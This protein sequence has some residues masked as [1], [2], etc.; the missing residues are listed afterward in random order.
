MSAN[1][2]TNSDHPVNDSGGNSTA[3]S[4]PLDHAISPVPGPLIPTPE[5]A[6]PTSTSTS[7]A[8]AT[9]PGAPIGP[10][11]LGHY[12]TTLRELNEFIKSGGLDALEKEKSREFENRRAEAAAIYPP[13]F[14]QQ[15]A[16]KLKIHD[17]DQIILMQDNLRMAAFVY[18]DRKRQREEEPEPDLPAMR[19]QFARLQKLSGELKREL[20][21]LV[22]PADQIFW[23]PQ[24]NLNA[25]SYMAQEAKSPFGHTIRRIALPHDSN[26]SGGPV[27]PG[28]PEMILY[29]KEHDLLEAVEILH[30][31]AEHACT[32]RS[33]RRR[34]PSDDALLQWVLNAQNFWERVFR[35][36]FSYA[37]H[38]GEG[39]T[40]AYIYCREALKVLDQSVT[41]SA[42]ATTMREAI[43]RR[44]G[45]T[46]RR[47]LRKLLALTK[48]PSARK[49]IMDEIAKLKSRARRAVRFRGRT[50]KN[51]AKPTEG[52]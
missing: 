4:N 8:S 11:G 48:D 32:L 35:Q 18:L 46:R 31:L 1:S 50:S 12:A 36:K 17:Q 2:P 30:N 19:P 49:K 52:F 42:I 14:I 22:K 51:P 10:S 13:E 15:L 27:F 43:A 38:K 28:P 6:D 20:E 40:V 16:Q 3:P 25:A 41:P 7:L 47:D 37:A 9:L 21:S 44:T 39:N 34:P 5:L 33:K 45:A 26:P 24:R 29:L 23:A